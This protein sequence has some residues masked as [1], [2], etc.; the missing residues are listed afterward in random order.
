[1]L[2]F[3]RVV[4][5]GAPSHVTE[6]A[7][8]LGRKY[9]GSLD[10]GVTRP[11][12]QKY[13]P[14][15]E[16]TDGYGFIV[17]PFENRVDVILMPPVRKL[18]EVPYVNT[19]VLRLIHGVVHNVFLK[20]GKKVTVYDTLDEY[21]EYPHSQITKDVA[22]E[23]GKPVN[24]KMPLDDSEH[25]SLW[26]HL[27]RVR[28][29]MYTGH[30]REVV[31]VGLG[32][33]YG[34]DVKDDQHEFKSV[35]YR[36][37]GLESDG[38]VFVKNEFPET[39]YKSAYE[40]IK[41]VAVRVDGLK[42]QLLVSDL[43]YWDEA[44]KN[45]PSYSD[46]KPRHQVWMEYA[47]LAQADGDTLVK[48]I[49]EVYG[50]IPTPESPFELATNLT[51]KVGSEKV[52][53]K[54]KAREQ[55]I[56]AGVYSRFDLSS[57][58][59]GWHAT[60][61]TRSWAFAYDS[62]KV[63][64]VQTKPEGGFPEM[65]LTTLAIKVTEQ[66]PKASQA[67]LDVIRAVRD[68]VI[69]NKLDALAATYKLNYAGDQLQALS[70]HFSVAAFDAI[71]VPPESRKYKV[72]VEVSFS[73]QMPLDNPVAFTNEGTKPRV[74]YKFPAYS[75][76]YIGCNT[77]LPT[78][79]VELGSG[80]R[81]RKYGSAPVDAFYSKDG[82]L[83][84]VEHDSS[85]GSGE[86]SVVESG[87]NP[88]C[89][90]VPWTYRREYSTNQHV[91]RAGLNRHSVYDNSVTNSADETKYSTTL[92]GGWIVTRNDRLDRP[93]LGYC[94]RKRHYRKATDVKRWDVVPYSSAHC[95]P[96]YER[97]VAYLGEPRRGKTY[98]H[99]SKEYSYGILQHPVSYGY[100]RCFPGYWQVNPEYFQCGGANPEGTCPLYPGQH[101]WWQ[102]H[103]YRRIVT[104]GP[105]SSPPSPCDQITGT[106]SWM[107]M[108]D[109]VD[110][111]A[112]ANQEFTLPPLPSG[113]PVVVDDEYTAA[114]Y[115]AG[116]GLGEGARPLFFEESPTASIT[117]M[118]DSLSPDPL[119][120][121]TAWAY[122]SNN[123]S[124]LQATSIDVSLSGRRGIKQLGAATE[125]PMKDLKHPIYVGV[126]IKGKDNA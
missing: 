82:D 62:P 122:V 7:N 121:F 74:H 49:I 84:L 83:V 63:V 19:P 106:S 59:D 32:I 72:S 70:G 58:F 103:H 124:G 116:T 126:A 68:N 66:K 79:F 110:L 47:A 22:S 114:I 42:K 115:A 87:E 21:K 28:P 43:I 20:H 33:G 102:T 123:C 109:D 45:I 36:L 30:L 34:S 67:P 73:H 9:A 98:T 12:D 52:P 78:P 29:S 65:R 13:I 71:E 57:V 90:A 54:A 117:A 96:M 18:P 95:A 94:G 53:D 27:T 69:L 44:I 1:M 39:N 24:F 97:E 113:G 15:T 35:T 37:D 41:P 56:K 23:A 25:A 107:Q 46:N 100:G 14:A 88:G 120:G 81:P 105:Y 11:G 6:V 5:E 4:G 125:A 112:D 104:D 118:W 93:D 92:I 101:S 111:V 85:P 17:R 31:Q 3:V 40:A 64:Q 86:D 119:T 10:V 75:G 91:W 38:V 99:A 89:E 80:K 48:R 76:A 2:P 61:T 50:G 8:N 16:D 51:K 108:C 60:D 26:S 55:R 77:W